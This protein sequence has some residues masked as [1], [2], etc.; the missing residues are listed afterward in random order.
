MKDFTKYLPQIVL[1]VLVL[2]GGYLLITSPKAAPVTEE[3]LETATTTETVS[4]EPTTPIPAGTPTTGLPSGVQ[5][6]TQT[7]WAPFNDPVW[8]ITFK[9]QTGW[10]FEVVN[11]SK[12]DVEQ[13][14]LTAKEGTVLVSR[15]KPIAE[16]KLITFTTSTETIAGQQTEVHTYTNP[17]EGYA[18]Y[19]F[20]S[21]TDGNDRYYVSIRSYVED[22]KW[23]A[24]FVSRIALK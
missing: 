20:F 1:V 3:S 18:Y 16:P 10:K 14:Y 8:D 2:I 17:K 5:V 19:R 24:A 22:Q 12:G 15:E 6:V 23:S 11:D 21:V 13:A 4:E 9:Y 7:I